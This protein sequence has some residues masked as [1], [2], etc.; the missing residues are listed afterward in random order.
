M[1][2]TDVAL[3]D[4]AEFALSDEFHALPADETR[5]ADLRRRLDEEGVVEL[6]DFLSEAG[7]ARLKQQIEELMSRAQ[8][9]NDK[10][11]IKGGD[12]DDT[13]VGELARSGYMTALANGLLGAVAGRPA[14]ISDPITSDEIVPGINIMRTTSDVTH[15]HFDG[16]YLNVILAVSIPKIQGSRR[17]QL[18]IYPNIRGFTRTLRGSY[19]APLSTRLT[20]VRRLLGRRRREVDYVERGAY[21]FYGYRSLH[22][23]EAQ[24][25]DGFRAITNMTVGGARFS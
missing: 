11:A 24:S 1:S 17:G 16:T 4:V 12:L 20:L 2:E 6:R 14:Y 25:E 15:F 18:V 22:G 7:H 13:L 19:L 9:A 3:G 8:A 5:V 21:L 23:V 10:L